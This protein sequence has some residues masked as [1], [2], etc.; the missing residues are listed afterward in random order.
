MLKGPKE[1]AVTQEKLRQTTQAKELADI[2]GTLYN[3]NIIIH[4]CKSIDSS[5]SWP[6]CEPWL[7]VCVCEDI[8]ACLSVSANSQVYF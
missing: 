5:L 6:L 7:C 2:E 1:P 3:N 4:A 8:V